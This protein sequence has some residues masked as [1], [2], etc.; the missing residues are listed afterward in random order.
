MRQDGSIEVD[1]QRLQKVLRKGN[2]TF[3]IAAKTEANQTG[4][5]SVN[6]HLKDVDVSPFNFT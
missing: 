2:F 5:A 1:W 6:L 3:F 4:Y